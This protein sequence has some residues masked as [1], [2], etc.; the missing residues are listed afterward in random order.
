MA[1][2]MK[3]VLHIGGKEIPLMT[4]DDPAYLRRLQE[5]TSRRLD[6]TASAA[7]VPVSAAALLCCLDLA[8]EV[9][10]TQ[11]EIRRIRIEDQ[12]LRSRME[13]EDAPQ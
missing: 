3:R 13:K 5:F 6:E 4:E 10:K 1:E 7:R 12:Q 11:D 2:K 9:L 8:D